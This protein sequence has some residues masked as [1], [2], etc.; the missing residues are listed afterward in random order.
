MRR[1]R[2]EDI[3]TD[4][5]T[6]DLIPADAEG[7]ASLLTRDRVVIAGIPEAEEV[8]RQLDFRVGIDWLVNEG[9]YIEGNSQ[10]AR[11]TRPARALLTGGRTTLNFI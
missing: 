11:F 5:V 8:F 6:A 4:D 9:D 1:A 2:D 3:R 10:L 7:Q